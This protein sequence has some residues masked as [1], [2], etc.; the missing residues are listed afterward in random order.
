ML[1][2]VMSWP[3]PD[4]LIPVES[5]PVPDRCGPAEPRGDPEL[6]GGA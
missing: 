3:D 1:M 6:N 2:S 4:C 5:N